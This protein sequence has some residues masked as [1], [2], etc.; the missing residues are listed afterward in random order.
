MAPLALTDAF[1]LAAVDGSKW[2]S[3]LQL[4]ADATG[5][6]RGQLIGIGGART[7]PFNWVTD[8]SDRALQEFIDIDGGSPTINPRVGASLH[9]LPLEIV[10]ERDYAFAATDLRSDVYLDYCRDYDIPHGCQTKLFEDREGLVGLATLR[11]FRDG[12]TTEAQRAVF[13]QI[14]PH[15]R[16]AV[17]IQRLLE[18]D[19]LKLVAGTLEAMSVAAFLCDA[20]GHVRSFTPL[21]ETLLQGGRLSLVGHELT[22]ESRTETERLRAAIHR[23][24]MFDQPVS[25]ASIAIR[26]DGSAE[27]LILDIA[28]LP[29]R[30]WNLLF[31]PRILVIARTAR[32]DP[33]VAASLLQVTY[34]LSAAEAEIALL[35][36]SGHKREAI[37]AAR[38]VTIATTRTQLKTI[39]LKLGVNRETE[40]VARLACF[41]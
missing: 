5:S 22:A 13:A 23:A 29:R 11:T 32:R 17:H 30:P 14:A 8:V 25:A 39:F 40:L 19:G 20:T 21:A 34:G 26:G 7:I 4:L 35:I 1:A 6:A 24:S 36:A 38:G 41:L 16:T 27:P 3:A 33:S 9:S 28:V 31:E 18:A 2:L 12:P 10:S 15:V 37:A